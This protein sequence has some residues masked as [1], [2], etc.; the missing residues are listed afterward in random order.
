M[1]K[2][3]QDGGRRWLHITSSFYKWYFHSSLFIILQLINYSFSWSSC[4]TWCFS[5]LSCILSRFIHFYRFHCWQ[6]LSCFGSVSRSLSMSLSCPYHAIV[7]V[8]SPSL[9]D[10]VY[11]FVIQCL[12]LWELFQLVPSCYFGNNGLSFF[13]SM[14]Q[15][16]RIGWLLV[17]WVSFWCLC[18]RLGKAYFN[19]MWN[20]KDTVIRLITA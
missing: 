9:W 12:C 11:F 7:H 13:C 6:A 10:G 1:H 8:I 2:H 14:V 3:K 5:R 20:G 16:L 18:L 17:F 19:Y 15:V 4:V